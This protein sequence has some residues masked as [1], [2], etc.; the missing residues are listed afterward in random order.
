MADIEPGTSAP[1]AINVKAVCYENIQLQTS[2]FKLFNSLF[3]SVYLVFL[4]EK[5]KRKK[6]QRGANRGSRL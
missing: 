2:R 6:Q 5:K 3:L 1:K 4:S